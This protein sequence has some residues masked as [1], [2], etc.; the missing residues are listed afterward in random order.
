MQ[1]ACAEEVTSL[2]LGVCRKLQLLG[3]CSAA[4]R[5]RG[6]R[7]ALMGELVNLY[8]T[9]YRDWAQQVCNMTMADDLDGWCHFCT[10]PDSIEWVHSRLVPRVVSVATRNTKVRSIRSSR[11]PHAP[12]HWR[13]TTGKLYRLDDLDVQLGGVCTTSTAE[14]FIQQ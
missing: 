13:R 14:R 2:A 3:E 6:R 11:P 1:E 8:R 4:G 12:L 10:P 9:F 7:E 5:Q